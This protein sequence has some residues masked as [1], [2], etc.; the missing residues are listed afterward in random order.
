MNGQIRFCGQVGLSIF[1]VFSLDFSGAILFRPTAAAL[2]D[3]NFS[4]QNA[5]G[6]PAA[7]SSDGFAAGVQD[8]CRSEKFGKSPE[9][10]R[11][12]QKISEKIPE[13]SRKISEPE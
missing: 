6:R 10:F 13:F 1:L 5:A 9:N 12:L 4:G 11:N 8:R 2:S 3:L 7:A